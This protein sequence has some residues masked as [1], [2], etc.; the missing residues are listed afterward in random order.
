MSP[1]S[2]RVCFDWHSILQESLMRSAEL[3]IKRWQI[4]QRE[5]ELITA[6]NQ[7]LPQVDAVALYR[8][9]G[10]GDDLIGKDNSPAFPRR[11]LR[12]LRRTVSRRLQEWRLGV[13]MATPIGFR[14][15]LAGVRNAQLALA[16]ECAILKKLNW[17]SCT[18]SPTAS[19]AWML[20]HCDANELQSPRGG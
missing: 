11:R 19:S 20:L 8:W 3:R 13:Q 7:L 14:R 15:E 5:T 18:R 4:K 2:A 1:S 10:R 6:R 16:R 12:R 17:N 9:L